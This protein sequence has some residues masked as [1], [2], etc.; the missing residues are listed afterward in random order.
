MELQASLPFL[1]DPGQDPKKKG[2][3]CEP[4]IMPGFMTSRG[5]DFNPV[6][7]MRLGY[8]ELFLCSKILLNCDRDRESF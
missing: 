7:E 2:C 1:E 8:L 3:C 5:E 6:S 4:C